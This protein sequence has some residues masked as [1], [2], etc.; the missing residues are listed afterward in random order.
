M[1]GV[2]TLFTQRLHSVYGIAHYV[3]QTTFNLVAHRHG[4]RMS[5]RYYFH[6]ALQSVRAIHSYGTHSVLANVLLN[7]DNQRSAVRSF[8]G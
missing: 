3:H 7:F 1:N 4:D 8:N 5:C 6:A 2:C